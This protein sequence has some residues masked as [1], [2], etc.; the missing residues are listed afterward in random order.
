MDVLGDFVDEYCEVG[1]GEQ[2]T[3]SRIY[4]AYVHWT[5]KT[6]EKPMSKIAFGKLL[7][8]RLVDLEEGRVPKS[9]ARYWRGIGLKSNRAD[10]DEP[11]TEIDENAPIDF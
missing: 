4:E 1:V 6:Q 3:K 11:R 5:G 7:V 10:A 9:R 8:G 2:V